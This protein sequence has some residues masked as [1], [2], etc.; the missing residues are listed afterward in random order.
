MTFGT[1]IALALAVWL[2]SCGASLLALYWN[3]VA[4]VQ[5]LRAAFISSCVALL[6][7]YWGVSQIQLNAS[8]TVNGRVAWSFHSRWF[9]IGAL[10]LG[11]ASLALTLWNWRK[12]SSRLAP[13]AQAGKACGSFADE[14]GATPNGGPATPC[15]S[16]GVTEGPPSVS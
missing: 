2:L 3:I 8:R 13:G 14:P 16:S 4:A 10:V 6:I 9:F 1:L 5:R 11:G 7:G 15:G 12:A